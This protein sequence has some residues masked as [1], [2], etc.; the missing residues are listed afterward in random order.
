MALKNHPQIS[1]ATTEKVKAIAERMGYQPNPTLALFSS[2]RKAKSANQ[3]QATIAWIDCSPTPN[4]MFNDYRASLGYFQGARRRAEEFGFRLEVFHLDKVEITERRLSH[5]LWSRGVSGLIIPPVPYLG[6][7][8]QLDWDR[9]SAVALSYSLVSPNLHRISF[10]QTIAGIL[11]VVKLKELGYRRIGFCPK[12]A[13]KLG[14]VD[15]SFLGGYLAGVHEVSDLATLPV[16]RSHPQ[17]ASAEKVKKQFLAWVESCQP[18]VVLAEDFPEPL[19]WLREA[20]YRVPEDIGFAE[21]WVNTNEEPI[22]GVNQQPEVIGAQAVDFLIGMMRRHERGIP[23]NPVRVLIDSQWM[24]GPTVRRI[25]PPA[26]MQEGAA[27]PN[28]AVEEMLASIPKG[29]GNS[30]SRSKGKRT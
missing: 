8:L 23:E 11:A 5:T 22:A 15:M 29:S 16:F 7:S 27:A 21:T 10:S 6:F 28:C 13:E 25:L 1:K 26:P 2:Y 19:K 4:Q 12:Q 30:K 9:F 24:D 17:G 18:D 3:F 20:G 14:I